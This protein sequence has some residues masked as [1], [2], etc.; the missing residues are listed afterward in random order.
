MKCNLIV[1]TNEL[2]VRDYTIIEDEGIGNLLALYPHI[3][4]TYEDDEK[5]PGGNM[6]V[7]TAPDL[8]SIFKFLDFAEIQV[9][10]IT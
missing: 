8:K 3:S 9:K 5:S 1:D 6:I 7:I 10:I 4:M 2:T